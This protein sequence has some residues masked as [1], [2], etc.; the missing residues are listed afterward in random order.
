MKLLCLFLVLSCLALAWSG[1]IDG[2]MKVKMPRH[3]DSMSAARSDSP[4]DKCSDICHDAGYKG[5]F[6]D[7]SFAGY[8]LCH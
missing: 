3:V 8:C 5:G 2:L 1:S 6:F 4:E 7:P